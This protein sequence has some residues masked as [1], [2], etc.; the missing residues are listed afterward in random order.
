MRRAA[1]SLTSLADL[2]AGRREGESGGSSGFGSS[3]GGCG[4]ARLGRSGSASEGMRRRYSDNGAAIAASLSGANLTLTRRRL[5]HTQSRLLQ[6]LRLSHKESR[7]AFFY[8]TEEAL[9]FAQRAF[10]KA[11]ARCA[12]H[13]SCDPRRA[14][15]RG[16]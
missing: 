14:N 5:Q 1:C 11:R 12:A 3:D 15:T 8:S 16:H 4:P 7:C 10:L 2:E 13:A 6:L 9:Q